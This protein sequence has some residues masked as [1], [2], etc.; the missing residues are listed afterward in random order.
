MTKG[1]L[2]ISSYVQIKDNQI[3][4]NG[5]NLFSQDGPFSEFIKLGYKQ[6]GVAYPKFFKMD[7]L[8]KLAL[9]AADILLKHEGVQPEN[10]ENI[11]LI[12]SNKASSLNTDRSH[13]ES[14]QNKDNYYPS[15]AVFVYTLPNICLGEISIKYK[16]YSENSFFIFDNF[17]AEHLYHYSQSLIQSKQAEKVLC[18]WVD[19]DNDTYEAFL[20]LV[21]KNGSHEH[22]INEINK[23]YKK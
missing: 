6:C 5:E 15:P 3:K 23:L 2:A 7:D 1:S 9:V 13:Q 4:L 10:E 8:S 21:S 20:Y 17:N 22:T 11:A 19:V 12:F 16:L 18:G 14:I